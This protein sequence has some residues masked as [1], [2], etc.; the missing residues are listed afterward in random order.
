MK[1]IQRQLDQL[2]RAD[3][4]RGPGVPGTD[5]SGPLGAHI[6]GD[7]SIPDRGK[8]ITVLICKL[9]QATYDTLNQFY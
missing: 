3:N 7:V 8:M 2:Q 6:S 4:K 5:L 1:N 9:N